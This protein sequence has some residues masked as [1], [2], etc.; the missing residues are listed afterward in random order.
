MASS[1]PPLFRLSTTSCHRRFGKRL[2]DV[3][4]AALTLTVLAP[5]LALIGVLIKM[6]SHGPVFYVQERIGK[7]GEP[8]PFIKFRTMRVGAEAGRRWCSVLERRPEGNGHRPAPPA[9]QRG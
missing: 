2:F 9:I 7:N 5:L 1:P 8:F 4:L 3:V 6:T